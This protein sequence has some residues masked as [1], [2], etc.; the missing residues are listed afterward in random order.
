MAGIDVWRALAAE[1]SCGRAAVLVAVVDGRGSSP[2]KAGDLLAVARSGPLAGTVGGGVGEAA[3][4]ERAMTLLARGESLRQALPLLLKQTHRTIAGSP[5]GMICGGEQ[6]IAIVPL[7]RSSLPAIEALLRALGAGRQACWAISSR[8]GG[9]IELAADGT[10]T[11]WPTGWQEDGDGWRYLARSGPDCE[12]WL[13]GGGHVSLALSA[14]LVR[15][16]FRV[17]VC[18]ERCGIASFEQ[19]THAHERL[20]CD[21]A[22]LGERIRAGRTSFVGIMTH[23][24]QGDRCCLAALAGK[25]LAYL[26]LLGSRSKIARLTAGLTLPDCFHAPMGLPIGS[27]TPDEIAVSIAA[28]MLLVRSRLAAT[29]AAALRES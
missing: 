17:V 29:R 22:G 23:D 19:N 26:G 9:G 8:P 6:R 27:H 21:Y 14:L 28:E 20:R 2:G 18:E 1:L 4:I 7:E 3:A 24:W 10:A 25:E 16:D 5:S 13:I 12:A 11:G 15:L